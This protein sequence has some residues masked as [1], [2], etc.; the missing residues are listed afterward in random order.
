MQRRAR[1]GSSAAPTST[2]SLRATSRPRPA[3]LWRG[4]GG[5]YVLQRL[6]PCAVA[7]Q[8]VAVPMRV[9]AA[10]APV[11]DLDQAVERLNSSDEP[12]LF[13]EDA[14]TGRGEILYHRYDGHHGLITPSAPLSGID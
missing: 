2:R 6:H 13:F 8:L 4:H 5:G 10:A 3:L 7:P 1:A 14:A 9:L 11:L 12:F